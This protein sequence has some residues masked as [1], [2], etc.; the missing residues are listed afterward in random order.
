MIER[1]S[2]NS[3]A[4]PVDAALALPVGDAKALSVVVIQEWWGLNEQIERTCERLAAD[5]FVALAPDLFHG[6][7]AKNGDEAKHLMEGLDW[8][9]AVQEIGGAV[10]Y[11]RGHARGNGHVAV[12][13][14]CMG[15]AL[16]LAAAVHIP[17]LAAVAP[18][19][20]VP[21]DLDWS[22]VTAPIQAHVSLHDDWATPAKVDAIQAR[23]K[24]PMDIF[25]YDAQHAFMNEKRPEVYSPECAA[26]AWQRLVTFLRAHA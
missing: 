12:T 19:Y 17:G 15:G 7:L 24:G 10:T 23:V 2:F 25:V 5:G 4:G 13:G 6:K 3:S 8:A 21:G 9:R 14:F 22:K 26:T 18:F 11:L 1:V 20:G 16:S